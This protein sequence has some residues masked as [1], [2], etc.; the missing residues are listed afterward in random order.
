MIHTSTTTQTSGNCVRIPRAREWRGS[1]SVWVSS[2]YTLGRWWHRL[3]LVVVKLP[4]WRL[5]IKEEVSCWNSRLWARKA[6]EEG[7]TR[8]RDVCGH[9]HPRSTQIHD[10]GDLSHGSL[11]LFINQHLR[12]LTLARGPIATFLDTCAWKLSYVI[13][14]CPD[15]RPKSLF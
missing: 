7:E 3:A 6:E 2:W 10:D 13:C 15:G 8:V 11:Y 9:S 5:E 14:Q 12:S 4:G 1:S